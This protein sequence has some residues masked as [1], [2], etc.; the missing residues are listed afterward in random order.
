MYERNAILDD[1]RSWVVEFTL[2]NNVVFRGTLKDEHLPDNFKSQKNIEEQFHLE[3]PNK[4]NCFGIVQRR[5]IS[6]DINDV[7]YVQLIDS[8]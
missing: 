1:L 2:K 7:L 8:Y 6:F 4:I 3:N 5:W